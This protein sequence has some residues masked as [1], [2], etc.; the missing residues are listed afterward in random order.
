MLRELGSHET[1]ATW[2]LGNT[3]SVSA[4]V[5]HLIHPIWII[6]GITGKRLVLLQKTFLMD[7]SPDLQPPMLL[8]PCLPQAETCSMER[9]LTAWLSEAN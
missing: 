8:Q 7:L 1:A 2:T 5:A 9:D 6:P 4:M 3:D